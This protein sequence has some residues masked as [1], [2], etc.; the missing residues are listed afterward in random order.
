MTAYEKNGL[1][2]DF[3]FDRPAD[4]PHL[5]IATLTASSPF[6]MTLTDFLFQAAVPKVLFFSFSVLF[7]K[8]QIVPRTTLA[9][10]NDSGCLV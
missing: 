4:N 6:G 10:V 3:A 2:V 8:F 5:V 7:L 9:T 1:R